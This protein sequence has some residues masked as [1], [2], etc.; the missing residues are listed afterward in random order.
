MVKLLACGCLLAGSS[1][2]GVLKVL[3]YRK[4]Y[5]ELIYIRYILNTVLITLEHHG[6]TFGE[7]CFLLARRF[8]PPYN[9]LFQG[10]YQTLEKERNEEP[11]VYWKEQIELVGRKVL[12]NKEEKAILQGLVRCM[13]TTTLSMPLDVIRQSLLEWDKAVSQAEEVCRDKSKVTLCLSVA[14]GVILCITVL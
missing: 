7:T 6:G 4:R 1:G 13:D 14:A 2:F 3:E 5:K 9:D 12:L 10:L 8:R 11:G